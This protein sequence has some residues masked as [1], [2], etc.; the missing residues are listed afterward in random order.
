MS[1][2]LGILYAICC[3]VFVMGDGD[4]GHDD[5]DN[6]DDDDDDDDDG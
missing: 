2:P 3:I 4:C 6:D 5:V 1:V